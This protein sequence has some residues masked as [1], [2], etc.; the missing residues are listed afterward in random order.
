VEIAEQLVSKLKAGGII[1]LSGI[2]QEDENDIS[3]CYKKYGAEVIDH[4]KLDEWLALVLKK[5][6]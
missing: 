5:V 3:I 4:L 6:D 2:L 1:I